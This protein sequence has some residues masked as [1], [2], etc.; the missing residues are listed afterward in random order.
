MTM[1]TPPNLQSIDEIVRR[2]NALDVYLAAKTPPQGT[3]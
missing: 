2:L 1:N 3:P